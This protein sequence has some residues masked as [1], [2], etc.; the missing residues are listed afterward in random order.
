MAPLKL[1]FICVD[2]VDYNRPP[3]KDYRYPANRL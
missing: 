1:V 3:I 2:K